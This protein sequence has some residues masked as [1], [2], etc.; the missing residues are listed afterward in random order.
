MPFVEDSVEPGS[1]L[2]TDGRRGYLPLKGKGY[3][4]EVTVLKESSKT[5]SELMLRVHLASQA[6]VHGNP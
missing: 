6:M 4:Q 3:R 5:A 1:V 2:H